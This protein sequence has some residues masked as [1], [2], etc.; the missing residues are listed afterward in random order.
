MQQPNNANSFQHNIIYICINDS[1]LYLCF[2][3]LGTL[4]MFYTIKIRVHPMTRKIDFLGRSFYNI[5]KP[6]SFAL[7]MLCCIAFMNNSSAM[8]LSL[9]LRVDYIRIF[10]R[11]K[12]C[13]YVSMCFVYFKVR[14][15]CLREILKI[16]DI[17]SVHL[18][19]PFG[20]HFEKFDYIYPYPLIFT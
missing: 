15:V 5:G 2:S 7:P 12:A 19:Q 14:I 8:S 6:S 18:R 17:K 1:L 16:L 11:Q 20:V 13:I 4:F 9:S 10:I 3:S